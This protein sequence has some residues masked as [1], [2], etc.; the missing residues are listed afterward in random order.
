MRNKIIGD[1]LILLLFFGAIWTVFTIF[2]I[3]P[4]ETDIGISV[5]R[6]E[7]IGDFIVENILGSSPEFDTIDN[8]M[9]DSAIEIITSRLESNISDSKYHYKFIIID[10]NKINAY[11]LPGGYIMIHSALIEFTETPEEL[12][13]VIAH[14][15]GHVEERHVISRILRELGLA[16][17]TSGDQYVLK[18]I[19]RFATS[20]AFNRR[21][22]KAADDFAMGLLAKSRINPRI[23]ATLFRRLNEEGNSYDKHLELLMTHPHNNKRIRSALEYDL[24][25]NFQTKEIE[26]NWDEVKKELLRVSVSSYCE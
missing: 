9:L 26:L 23:I 10:N 12:A 14:E 21:Q 1:L 5:E 22:E 24:E 8:F 16:V 20:S 17:L 19:G 18:E 15:M 7:E 11:A 3:L 25:D 13:A 6:E 4:D 2:P